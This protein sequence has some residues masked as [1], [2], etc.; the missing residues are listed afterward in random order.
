[1]R[2]VQSSV[3]A[4]INFCLMD[5]S[6]SWINQTLVKLDKITHGHGLVYYGIDEAGFAFEE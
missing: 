1:M 2:R 4:P 6:F 3:Q 5:C